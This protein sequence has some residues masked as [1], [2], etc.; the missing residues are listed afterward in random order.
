MGRYSHLLGSDSGS[1]P[2]LAA[3]YRR[4]QKEVL[5]LTGCA[6]LSSKQEKRPPEQERV[7][8]VYATYPPNDGPRVPHLEVRR[9]QLR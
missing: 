1:S 4:G 7:S 9:S 2:Y 5:P 6:L 8:A 3:S